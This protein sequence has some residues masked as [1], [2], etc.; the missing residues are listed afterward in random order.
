MLHFLLHIPSQSWLQKSLEQGPGA[1]GRKED[2]AI[3][4]FR[5]VCKLLGALKMDADRSRYALLGTESKQ[6]DQ[7]IRNRIPKGCFSV[8]VGIEKQRFFVPIQYL[9]HPMIRSLLA[10]SAEEYGFQ[11]MGVLNIPCDVH[12]FRLVLSIVHSDQF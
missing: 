7:D 1:E 5:K 6:D 4:S 12:S 11:Q 10:M 8:C 3:R 9:K 2:M